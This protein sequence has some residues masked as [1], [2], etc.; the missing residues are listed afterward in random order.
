MLQKTNGIVLRSIK[1]GES[2]LVTTIFT[3]Q[4][5]V[6]T[7][8][9]QGVRSSSAK[10]NRAGSFQPATL[11]ELVVFQQ[12]H[13]NMQRLREFHPAYIYQ[14]LQ[15]DVIKNSIVLFSVEIMLRLLPEHAS[16]PVLF[17]FAFDYFITLDKTPHNSIA[18][19][20]LFFIIRC[21]KILGYELKGH[22]SLATPHLNLHE[23]GFTAEAPDAIPFTNDEDAIILSALL[24]KEDYTS[25]WEIQMSAAM[26]LRL[27]DWY[28]SFLQLHTQHMGNIRSLSVLRTIL[29]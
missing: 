7:F 21:S 9:V 3:A 19:F 20:P 27:I 28:I 29:H 4:H 23:G 18:N 11:L 8:M 15:E 26:R 12:P 14:T 25:L 5:G 16:L 10:Q 17:D 6:E 2:S 24:V 13:K 1:Y 22:Y